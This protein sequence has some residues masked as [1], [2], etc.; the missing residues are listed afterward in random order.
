[1]SDMTEIINSDSTHIHAHF[2]G[3][4][5]FKFLFLSCE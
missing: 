3:N 4:D 1:M 2:A 5:W